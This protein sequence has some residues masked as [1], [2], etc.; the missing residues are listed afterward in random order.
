M[1]NG[2]IS[3]FPNVPV[4]MVMVYNQLDNQAVMFASRL[5]CIMGCTSVLA[6]SCVIS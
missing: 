5:L 2:N 3:K 1:F 4:V 6:M